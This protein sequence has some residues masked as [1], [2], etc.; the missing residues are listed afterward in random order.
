[1]AK[2][3]TGLFLSAALA[4]LI[5]NPTVEAGETDFPKVLSMRERVDLVNTITLKRLNLL[6]PKFMRETG[7]RMISIRSLKP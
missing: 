4:I 3:I 6:V 7:M 2:K 1:V 5:L